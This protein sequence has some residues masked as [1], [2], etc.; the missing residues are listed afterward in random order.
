MASNDEMTAKLAEL[1]STLT[2]YEVEYNLKADEADQMNEKVCKSE[3]LVTEAEKR[4]L[5]LKIEVKRYKEK[6]QDLEAELEQ[7]RQKNVD[8][9]SLNA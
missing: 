1:Q 9:H 7:I 4:C 6:S 2:Q 8:T 5:E 3:T